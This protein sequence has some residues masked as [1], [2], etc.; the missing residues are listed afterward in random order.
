M[1]RRPSSR[2]PLVGSI[3]VLL[4]QSAMRTSSRRQRTL[5]IVRQWALVLTHDAQPS[6][7][8]VLQTSLLGHWTR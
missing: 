1:G 2:P 3:F 5:R 8:H 7:C 6:R 4:K